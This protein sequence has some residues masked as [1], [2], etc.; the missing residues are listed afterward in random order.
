MHSVISIRRDISGS[1]CRCS[2]VGDGGCGGGVRHREALRLT[3]ADAWSTQ[4]QVL[5]VD[6]SRATLARAVTLGQSE[7]TARVRGPAPTA[8]RLRRQ[9]CRQQRR[10]APC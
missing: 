5:L 6:R 3:R 10:W 7:A 1:S 8:A 9:Q 2:V 4:T